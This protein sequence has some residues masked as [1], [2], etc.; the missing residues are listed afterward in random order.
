MVEIDTEKDGARFFA[1]SHIHDFCE[2]CGEPAT[3]ECDY[4]AVW[5]IRVPDMECTT[6][7]ACDG[8]LCWCEYK[9]CDA[10]L[11]D[12]HAHVDERPGAHVLLVGEETIAPRWDLCPKHSK[13]P[14]VQVMTKDPD[15]GGE[16]P[17]RRRR[18]PVQRVAVDSRRAR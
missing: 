16:P 10:L 1:C 17:R 11:C 4:G 6:C 14:L 12:I 18:P 2:V 9:T 5:S 3:R 7:G 8:A 13:V 15:G